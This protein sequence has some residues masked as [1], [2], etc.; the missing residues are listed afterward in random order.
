VT[1]HDLAPHEAAIPLALAVARWAVQRWPGLARTSRNTSQRQTE[2][3][4]SPTLD[5]SLMCS[6]PRA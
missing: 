5:P 1:Q 3:R 2:R 4:E 6:R